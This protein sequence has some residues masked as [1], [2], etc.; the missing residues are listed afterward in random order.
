MFSLC[1]KNSAVDT[2]KMQ[3]GDRFIEGLIKPRQ[4]AR[5]NL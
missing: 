3:S 1:P 4:E 5:K 2:L